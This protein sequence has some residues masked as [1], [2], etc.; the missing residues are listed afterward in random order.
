MLEI[1]WLGHGS[2]QFKLSTGEVIVI[3]PWLEGP[4][5]PKGHSFDRIDTILITH[6]HFDHL[7]DAVP[8]ALKFKPAVIANFEISVWLGSKGVE[9][10]TGMNLGGT[11]Q[12]GPVN[13]TMTHAFHSSG[14]MEDGK[15]I[16][17]G[18]AAGFVIELPDSRKIYFAGDTDVFSEMSLIGELH[19]PALAFLPIGD[20]Y[21]MS[22]REAAVACRLLKPQKVIG[23]H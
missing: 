9:N 22:P 2:F 21:T 11:T 18:E 14:I 7:P 15:M 16:Y 3:D 1:T 17:G 4:T 19:Q 13:V 23:M 6:G 8:L 12:A 10:I 20:L 5:Y